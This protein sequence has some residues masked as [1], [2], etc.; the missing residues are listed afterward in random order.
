MFS[1]GVCHLF[2]CG[3]PH[4]SKGWL[5]WIMDWWMSIVANSLTFSFI[6]LLQKATN[7]KQCLKHLFFFFL[8]RPHQAQH[9][10]IRAVTVLYYS[11]RVVLTVQLGL[12][13]SQRFLFSSLP[14][15]WWNSFTGEAN[16]SCMPPPQHT[17]SHRCTPHPQRLSLKDSHCQ[18]IP[19]T[20][21]RSTYKVNLDGGCIKKGHNWRAPPLCRSFLTF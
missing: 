18:S 3:S 6:Y 15:D 13:E 2:L 21:L 16:S 1:I 8:S 12:N 9:R 5:V 19:P 7:V 10:P 11:L 17:H 14:V 4:N 20:P